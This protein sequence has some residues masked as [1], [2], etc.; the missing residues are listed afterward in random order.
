MSVLLICP[1]RREAVAALMEAEP[2]VNAPLLGESLI[3][4]WLEYLVEQGTTEVQI[5]ASDRPE[6][7]RALVG[8]GARW[9]LK[10]SVHPESHELTADEARR[11]FAAEDEDAPPTPREIIVLDHLP[12]SSI[13]LF[14]SYLEFFAGLLEWLPRAMTPDRVGMHEIRPGVWVGAHS[15]I[16]ANAQLRSPCWI[17]EDVYVGPRAVIG[18]QAI[19]ETGAFIESDAEIVE[20][21]IGP[22]TSIGK[23]IEVRCSMAMGSTLTNWRLNSCVRVRDAFL[24]SGMTTA[25]ARLRR[26]G[27]AGRMVAFLALVVSAPFA[28]AAALCAKR[29]GSPMFRALLAARPRPVTAEPVPGDTVVYYELAEVNG[30]LRRWPQLWNIV[31][32]EFNWVGNRPLTL[33]QADALSN[34]YERLWLAAPLGLVSLADAEGCCALRSDEARA[35]ASYYAAHAGWRLDM[36]VLLRTLFLLLVG[37]PWSRGCEAT[38]RL[39][40]HLGIVERRPYRK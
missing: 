33:R 6:Q 23:Y 10:V 18:P 3:E 17:G 32:G 21:V 4:Y 29:R 31:R 24:L 28:L 12:G 27:V 39:L 16:A 30:V 19:L 13:P 40:Q 8:D 9:G 5:L 15:H 36:I 20:S 11:K 34:D 38:A 35:H 26:G 1:E 2:L 37:I 25:S 7:V 22:E 14:G